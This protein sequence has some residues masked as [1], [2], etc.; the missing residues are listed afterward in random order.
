MN[1]LFF[2]RAL[3]FVG[4]QENST[5]GEDNELITSWLKICLP[6]QYLY[7]GKSDET[8]W[9]AAFI[10][11]V[12]I[13][14]FGWKAWIEHVKTPGANSLAKSF[15]KLAKTPYFKIVRRRDVRRGDILIF[16]RGKYSWQGH[17]TICA[18]DGS[19]ENAKFVKGLGGNQNNKVG[20]I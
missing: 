19:L 14:A 1:D 15:A 5:A 8:S 6:D 4:L 13:E 3:D 2:E 12:F 11:G 9:C 18:K 10:H 17:I 7:A 20:I 16:N